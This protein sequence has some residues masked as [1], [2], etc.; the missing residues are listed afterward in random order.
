MAVPKAEWRFF[1]SLICLLYLPSKVTALWM[2]LLVWGHQCYSV[3]QSELYGHQNQFDVVCF[4][5]CLDWH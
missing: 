2:V 4:Y 1:S 5:E 3:T